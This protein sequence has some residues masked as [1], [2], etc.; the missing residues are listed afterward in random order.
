[1]LTLDT[2]EAAGQALAD[3]DDLRAR[4]SECER[5]RDPAEERAEEAERQLAAVVEVLREVM[6]HWCPIEPVGPDMEIA[7]RAR[8]VLDAALAKMKEEE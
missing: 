7:G 1:V 6:E 5:E 4:L 3:V 8:A 2:L